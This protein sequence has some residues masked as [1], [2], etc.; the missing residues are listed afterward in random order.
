MG[1]RAVGVAALGFPRCWPRRSAHQGMPAVNLALPEAS[2]PEPETPRPKVVPAY[3]WSQPFGTGVETLE[4]LAGS[5]GTLEPAWAHLAEKSTT[6]Q[7]QRCRP[8]QSLTFPCQATARPGQPAAGGS[9]EV[10]CMLPG[11][12]APAPPVISTAEVPF[13]VT[14]TARRAAQ[15][16]P[17]AQVARRHALPQC[18]ESPPAPPLCN[19][20]QAVKPITACTAGALSRVRARAGNS[21]NGACYPSRNPYREECSTSWPRLALTVQQSGTRIGG[22]QI[23]RWQ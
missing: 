15:Q 11:A 19:T 10:A 8:L 22:I 1:R 12:P 3:W 2:H 6:S 23:A 20:G 9:G 21:S 5:H 14:T 17:V 16:R 13:F 4:R 18:K 7:R